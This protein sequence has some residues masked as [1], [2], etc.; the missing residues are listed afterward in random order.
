MTGTFIIL[1]SAMV[2]DELIGDPPYRLHPV[3]LMGTLFQRIE[4]IFRD[5]E[6]SSRSHTAGRLQGIS[7]LALCTVITITVPYLLFRVLDSLSAPLAWL[8][9]IFVYFSMYAQ[10]DLLLHGKNVLTALEENSLSAA[11]KRVSFM[12]GRNTEVLDKPG[13]IRAVVESLA[14]NYVDGSF[15]L[16]SGTVAILS[17]AILLDF[18]PMIPVLIWAVFFR[19]VNTLDAMVGYMNDKYRYFGWASAKMDDLLNYLPA[20]LSIFPLA[21][22]VVLSHTNVKRAFSDFFHFRKSTL[23]PNSGHPESFIA[24]ALNIPLGGPIVYRE[25]VVDKGWIGNGNDV[26]NT[27]HLVKAMKIISIAGRTHLWGLA[28]LAALF[29]W[30][31]HR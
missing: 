26:P 6:Q 25:G 3:R 27:G 9:G 29:A 20:R 31:S 2:L 28:L 30:C 18:D 19:T 1:L 8:F 13:I 23:S 11:R 16:F 14:E 22:G 17:G 7:Y 15:T 24:G 10:K 21:M 12:V 5:E 4:K